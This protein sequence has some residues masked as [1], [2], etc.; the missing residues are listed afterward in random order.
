MSDNPKNENLPAPL[1]EVGEYVLV[2]DYTYCE[3]GHGVIEKVEGIS[4]ENDKVYYTFKL[5]IV[6]RFPSDKQHIETIE[7]DIAEDFVKSIDTLISQ[8]YAISRRKGGAFNETIIRS[9]DKENKK[10]SFYDKFSN[11]SLELKYS[12]IIIREAFEDLKI[13][14][15]SYTGFCID[16]FNIQNHIFFEKFTWNLNPRLNIVSG[17]NGYGKT[18]LL[19]MLSFMAINR[20]T[21]SF[22]IVEELRNELF[23]ERKGDIAEL[24]IMREELETKICIREHQY[25]ENELGYWK[26][27]SR[28]NKGFDWYGKN[29]FDVAHV[30]PLIVISA[31]RFINSQNKSIAQGE[32]TDNFIL[33]CNQDFL[34]HGTCNTL[35]DALLSEIVTGEEKT[36]EKLAEIPIVRLIN[37][38]FESLGLS[39]RLYSVGVNPRNTFRKILYVVPDIKHPEAEKNKIPIQKASTGIIS[40]LT[41]VGFIYKGLES[42]YYS[43]DAS[44]K[45][46]KIEEA[47]G[48]VIIDE[49]DAHLHPTLERD[50]LRVLLDVFPNVQFIV[51]SHSPLL[52]LDAEN[53][54]VVRLGYNETTGKHT[55]EVKEHSFWGLPYREIYREVFDFGLEEEFGVKSWEIYQEYQQEDALKKL[56]Q[57]AK[58]GN[59]QMESM[60]EKQKEE[61]RETLKKLAIIKNIRHY[62]A[63]S[64]TLLTS[65]TPKNDKHENP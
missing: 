7:K 45:P 12:D 59:A 64:A 21:Q 58:E 53:G 56:L 65:Y 3:Y 44:Q 51:A 13:E 18:L 35:L 60:T 62:L 22:D 40:I 23:S 49:L 61:H 39:F 57:I 26:Y 52:E 34:T 19:R 38:I 41:I 16:T 54:Q 11:L 29:I 43:L 6:E 10:L 4:I 1:F 32:H 25:L 48:T 33:Q 15:Y 17:K 20:T 63:N 47:Y 2:P 55:L 37:R 8:K 30:N 31:T 27:F 42:Y 5:P 46:D 14:K 9:N 24:G 36:P 28:K 50:L